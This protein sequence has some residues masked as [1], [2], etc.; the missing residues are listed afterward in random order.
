MKAGAVK[1]NR[2]RFQHR[3]NSADQNVSL[4]KVH[5]ARR[6]VRVLSAD[7]L[8]AQNR[9]QARQSGSNFAVLGATPRRSRKI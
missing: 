3:G 8:V 7:I 1:K 4:L 9:V 5:T 6:I 2:L